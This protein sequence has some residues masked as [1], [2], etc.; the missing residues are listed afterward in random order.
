METVVGL[1]GIVG[2]VLIASSY[3]VTKSGRVDKRYA[4]Q[5]GRFWLGVALIGLGILLAGLC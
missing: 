2:L 4:F 3:V 1:V 5:L